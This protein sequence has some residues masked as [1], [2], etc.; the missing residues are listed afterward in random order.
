MPL[1][2][3]EVETAMSRV[4]AGWQRNFLSSFILCFGVITLFS[5]SSFYRT[6][7]QKVNEMKENSQDPLSD[8][9]FPRREKKRIEE[10]H[11]AELEK[12]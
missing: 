6:P 5:F 9:L 1:T 8:F 4:D 3:L 11:G 2:A 7:K 10:K 12:S